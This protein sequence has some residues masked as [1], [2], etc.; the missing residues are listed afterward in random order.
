MSYLIRRR[1]LGRTSVREIAR[2]STT[3]LRGFR[4]DQIGTPLDAPFIFRWGC[5]SNVGEG[6]IVNT[7]EAIHLVSDK[8]A[9]RK[10]LDEAD[11]CP[12]TWVAGEEESIS[13]PCVIRPG[14]H[15]QGRHLYV[16]N[17]QA[18]L[19]SA[20]ARARAY[21]LG[22]GT[23]YASP[24]INKV[25]EYRVFCVQGRVTCVARKH[26]GNPDQVAWNVA[27]G[28]RFENVRFDEW[29]LKAVRISLEAFGLSGLDFGGVDVMVDQQGD[30]FVL[31]IN[32]A[33]SLTSPYRQQCMAKAFDYIIQQGSK[34]AIP[35]RTERG[36]WKK[37]VHPAINENARI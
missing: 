15:H 36:D 24:L 29:P 21:R 37:F 17:N 12:T 6:T 16:A 22:G 23:W 18:E 10:I 19:I 13:F 5:T 11:L 7:S 14:V 25:A 26:P 32:S 30:C 9:F 8:I 4:N 20:I 31:E 34:K 3:G 33:P 1:K 2:Y 27:Q 28:G 35:L